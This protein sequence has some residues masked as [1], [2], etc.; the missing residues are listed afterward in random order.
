MLQ[1]L[2]GIERVTAL[3]VRDA[4]LAGLARF[5]RLSEEAIR[6]PLAA[7]IGAIRSA[8]PL[9]GCPLSRPSR[10]Q[11]IRVESIAPVADLENTGRQSGI[12]APLE[13]MPQADPL[14]TLQWLQVRVKPDRCREIR[15]GAHRPPWDDAG[16]KA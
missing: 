14:M 9:G 4:L 12:A 15:P 3:R 10:E 11:V 8:S 6:R 13:R 7:D 16:A 5:P 2:C 1:R